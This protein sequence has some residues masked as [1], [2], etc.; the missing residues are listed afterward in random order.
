ME[1]LYLT[2]PFLNSGG[3]FSFTGTPTAFARPGPLLSKEGREGRPGPFF[4]GF[5]FGS[6]GTGV[7][8]QVARAAVAGAP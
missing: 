7:R 2:P 5:F 1:S 6:A 3:A 8:C 4:F